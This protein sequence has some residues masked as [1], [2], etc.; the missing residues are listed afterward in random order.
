MENLRV[1]VV[2]GHEVV[3]IGVRSIIE[4]QQG[5]KVAGEAATGKDGIELAERLAPHIV[6]T[7]VS[8]P[9]VN[10]LEATKRIVERSDRVRVLVL[11][12][13]KLDQ[14][15][16]QAL[17]AGAR[18]IVLKS[19]ASS[20]I[21]HAVK[22]VHEGK[23]YLTPTVSDSILGM[24][25]SPRTEGKSDGLTPRERE[26]VRL[27]CQGEPNKSIAASLEIS[28]RT[29]ETHRARVMKKLNLHSMGDLVRWAIR[30]HVADL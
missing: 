23:V 19:D 9:D 27:V 17:E 8:L 25:S 21:V 16:R 30:N 14:M 11:T 2:D 22:A 6:V 28:V 10:G 7:D 18:G 3:R 15:W 13:Y 5:W 26:I 12:M 4:S 29:V 1:L 20:E 24:I